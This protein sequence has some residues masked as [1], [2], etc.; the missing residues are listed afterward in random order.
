MLLKLDFEKAFDML[1]HDTIL[2]ILKVK[3]FGQKW[4][5]W[6]KMIYS[7]VFSSVLLNGVPGKQ[8]KCK[9]GV[10]Q[11]DPLSPLISVQAAELLQSMLNEAML[12]EMIVAPIQHN[13]CPDFPVIQ[14]VDD[15]IMV[16]PAEKRQ[17]NHIKNLLLHFANFTGLHVNYC[18]STMISINTPDRNMQVLSNLMGC[19]I[20]TL[21]IT[22]L[23]L[24]LSLSRPKIEDFTPM[25]CR[26]EKRLLGCSI[27]FH[28]GINLFW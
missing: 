14:Y 15:I 1:S 12:S 18:K 17:V 28:M 26:I 9:Q 25:L 23:G 20:G 27:C 19:Q 8:F 4:L 22:Y 11:G 6:I 10:R 7:S 2:K 3:G 21:P 16:L 24:P 13:T 5:D